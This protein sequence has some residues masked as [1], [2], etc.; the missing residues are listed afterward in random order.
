M[1]RSIAVLAGACAA[2]FWSGVAEAENVLILAGNDEANVASLEILGDGNR[3]AV[4]QT[5]DE[6]G[7]GNSIAGSITGDRNGL[8]GATFSPLL[9]SPGLVPGSMD[10]STLGAGSA[11]GRWTHHSAAEP[12]PSTASEA[13]RNRVRKKRRTAKVGG[14]AGCAAGPEGP[15]APAERNGS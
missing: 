14:R 4:D 13:S 12:A 8:S 5:F 7:G 11:I 9:D 6:A 15:P 1:R 3:I 2:L 10:R